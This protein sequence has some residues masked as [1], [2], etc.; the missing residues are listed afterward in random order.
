MSN[1][2]QMSM[3]QITRQFETNYTTGHIE[4]DRKLT[5]QDAAA[6]L[7]Q[8]RTVVAELQWA[9]ERSGD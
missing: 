9:V 6:G 7:Q 5:Y 8:G 4:C 3:Q 1:L 2:I